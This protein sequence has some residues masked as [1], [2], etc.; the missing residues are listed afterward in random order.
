MKNRIL[1]ALFCGITSSIIF[2]VL[3]ES[4]QLFNIFFGGVS[5]LMFSAFSHRIQREKHHDFWGIWSIPY[6]LLLFKDMITSTLQVARG[7]FFK[8]PPTIS[9]LHME[10]HTSERGKVLVSNSITLTPGT[11][12]LEERDSS[13]TI[14][15]MDVSQSQENKQQLANAFENRIKERSY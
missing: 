10:T 1:S 3:L 5:G 15:H 7:I 13:Y 14:L 12:T 4:I 11:I 6:Y 9:I 8:T 2:C